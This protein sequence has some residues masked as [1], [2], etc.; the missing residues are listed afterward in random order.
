MF[1]EDTQTHT[2]T[3][4]EQNDTQTVLNEEVAAS[5]QQ[6]PAKGKAINLKQAA[7]FVA[8]AAAGAAASVAVDAFA[9]RTIGEPTVETEEDLDTEA[10]PAPEAE[11]V[12]TPTPQ[13]TPQPQVREAQPDPAVRQA[14]HQ[15]PQ[16]QTERGEDQFFRDHEVKIQE[17]GTHE[18]SDGHVVHTAAGTV[19]GHNAVFVDDGHGTVTEYAVDQNDNQQIEDS[20][21]VHVEGQDLTM[22]DLAEHLVEVEAVPEPTA[23]Q[24]SDVRVIAVENDVT[25]GEHTV[26]VAMVTVGDTEGLLIDANQDGEVNVMAM[27]ANHDG[28]FSENELQNVTGAHIPM[29]TQEDTQSYVAQTDDLPDYSNDSDITVYDV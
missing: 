24:A 11:P 6:K 4:G 17:I 19:N 9:N 7:G 15:E 12:V 20:E 5:E 2:R 10:E 28:D 14:V 29:P 21:I 8:G 3:M 16:Q 26:N 13:P 1:T 18:T 27:D 23:T 22:G 25:M